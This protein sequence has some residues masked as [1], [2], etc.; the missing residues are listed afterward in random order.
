MDVVVALLLIRIVGL[1]STAWQLRLP[2]HISMK[3]LA[4][5]VAV[6]TINQTLLQGLVDMFK[7]L[8]MM[9]N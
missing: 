5:L 2:I 6:D 8:Q 1:K 4:I 9:K 3:E 7:F